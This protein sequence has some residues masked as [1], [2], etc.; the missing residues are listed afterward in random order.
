MTSPRTSQRN[1]HACAHH[2]NKLSLR[3][4]CCCCRCILHLQQYSRRL[5]LLRF[6]F[7][8]LLLPLMYL[9]FSRHSLLHSFI[10]FTYTWQFNRDLP[11]NKGREF[12][13][14]S[15]HFLLIWLEELFCLF[16]PFRWD[17]GFC[18]FLPHSSFLC[19]QTPSHSLLTFCHSHRWQ[20]CTTAQALHTDNLVRVTAYSPGLFWLILATT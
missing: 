19:S 4:Y 16:Q 15:Q 8:T 11:N 10:S 20:M 3:V 12:S 17:C 14:K 7:V 1:R 5:N 2:R 9:N 6:F 18:H 13:S